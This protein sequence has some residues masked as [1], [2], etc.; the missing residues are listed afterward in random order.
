MKAKAREVQVDYILNVGDNFYWG[1]ID[2]DCSNTRPEEGSGVDPTTQ[3]DQQFSQMYGGEGMDGKPWL[4]VLGNHDYGGA[5][6]AQIFRTWTATDGTWRMPAQ[7]WSQRVQYKDFSVQYLMLD[8]SKIDAHS[9]PGHNFCNPNLGRMGAFGCWDVGYDNCA[10]VFDQMWTDGLQMMQ[11]VLA[12][13]TADYHI[14]VSHFPGEAIIQM[15]GPD[16]GIAALHNQ[17]G[18]DLV[19]TGHTHNQQFAEESKSGIKY[20]ITGGGGGITPDGAHNLCEG[21]QN[22]YGYVWFEINRTQ[23]TSHMM[24]WGGCTT[25]DGQDPFVAQQEME[26]HAIYPHSKTERIAMVTSV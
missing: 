22:G 2:A 25:C 12:K 10:S 19:L 6:D 11:E 9:D 24:S 23:L 13:K 26:V 21:N 8:S 20:I 15:D 1:G 5:W 7:F 4:S 18:I 14:I 16:S 17:Y 3:W